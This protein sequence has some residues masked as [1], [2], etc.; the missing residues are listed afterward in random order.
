M[1][2][3]YGDLVVLTKK[4]SIIE[5]LKKNHKKIC[6]RSAVST[7]HRIYNVEWVS[8]YKQNEFSYRYLHKEGNMLLYG[9][10]K[11]VYYCPRYHFERVQIK[12]ILEQLKGTPITIVGSGISPYS[13]I[14]SENHEITE[15]EPNQRAVHYGAINLKLNNCTATTYAQEYNGQPNKIILSM[16][17]AAPREFH[18]SYT[19]E[20]C[21]IF[22][23]L[24]DQSELEPY[25]KLIE[26]HYQTPVEHRMVRGYSKTQRIYRFILVKSD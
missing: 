23:V 10:V 18:L 1:Y 7:A 4:G 22:Y 21:C 8:P 24:L 16:V 13:I 9:D 15:F 20:K 6:V 11:Q 17:P 12:K 2:D 14:L 19:F 5:L 25:V 26:T 3:I